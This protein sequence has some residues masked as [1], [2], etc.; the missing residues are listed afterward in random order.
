ML[1]TDDYLSW[2]VKLL[3]YLYW[4]GTCCTLREKATKT[5]RQHIS[6]LRRMICCRCRVV[7]AVIRNCTMFLTPT[8]LLD[9]RGK[10]IDKKVSFTGIR[11]YGRYLEGAR[12]RLSAVIWQKE[13]QALQ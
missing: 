12:K 4:S 8:I 6:K 3:E 11:T 10:Y 1:L 9:F 7:F 13:M 5:A 2:N